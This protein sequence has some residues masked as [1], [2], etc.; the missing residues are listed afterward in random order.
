M[1]PAHTT[2]Q[3]RSSNR[4]PQANDWLADQYLRAAALIEADTVAV[5]EMLAAQGVAAR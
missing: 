5:G 2:R 1:I 4:A 3:A